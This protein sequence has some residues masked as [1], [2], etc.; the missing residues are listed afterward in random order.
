MLGCA[1]ADAR[2]KRSKTAKA[3]FPPRALLP[4]HWGSEGA[5]KGIVIG[6]I[7][8]LACGGIQSPVFYLISGK[9]LSNVGVPSAAK[10]AFMKKCESGK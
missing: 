4:H 7:V 1:L 9:E 3:K 8:P 2:T 10:E 5:C 6:Y